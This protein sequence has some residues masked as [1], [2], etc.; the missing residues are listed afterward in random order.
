MQPHTATA[1][2]PLRLIGGGGHALVVA[3]VAGLAG[4]R[5][6]GFYDDN[7]RAACAARG[8]TPW[9]GPLSEARG[10]RGA[11]VLAIGDLATRRRVLDAGLADCTFADVWWC[12]RAMID[13]A[14]ARVGAGVLLAVQSVV[15]P[16]ATIGAHAII[17]TGAV[18]E[19]E[20]DIGENTHIAPGA[21]LGG[22]VRV[23]RDTLIGLGGRV[24]PG[25]RIGS[26][27][28][29]GAGA[30]VTADVPD[31]AVVV[32]VPARVRTASPSERRA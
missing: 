9:L 22:N 12:D 19:H 4:W 24:L 7:P 14:R 20:C 17:N 10:A 6:E 21:V 8:M 15:Q 5:V 27:C 2:R 29:I 25:V 28:V 30:V 23:G 26:G 13:H 32:G 16:F 31:C 1:L 18:V 11:V 3:H